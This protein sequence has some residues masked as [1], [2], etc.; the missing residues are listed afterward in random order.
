[1]STVSELNEAMERYGDPAS[2][3]KV[4][5]QCG[6]KLFADMD[7]CYACLYDYRAA[8]N[9]RGDQLMPGVGHG[10]TRRADTMPEQSV[11]TPP[12]PARVTALEHPLPADMRPTPPQPSSQELCHAEDSEPQMAAN[13]G[14]QEYLRVMTEDMDVMMPVPAEGLVVG[15]RDDCDLVVRNPC[16]ISV[17]AR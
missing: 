13:P 10:V 11:T 1:M 15:P 17:C 12:S 14:S 8:Q 2:R 4:C 5:P 3:L 9:E 7:V 6:E 16:R